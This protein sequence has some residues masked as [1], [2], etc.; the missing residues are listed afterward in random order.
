MGAGLGN[1]VKNPNNNYGPQFGFAWDPSKTGKTVIRGGAGL[2]YENYI[3]NNTLFDRPNKLSQGLFFGSG[4]IEL[5]QPR[6]ARLRFIQPAQSDGY[7]HV[8]EW[9]GFSYRGLPA[10]LVGSSVRWLSDL[11]QEYQAAAKAL[12]P[13]S[14]A[15]F[16]GNDLTLNTRVVGPAF[17]PNF[18][19]ARSYQMNIG[20]QRQLAQGRVDCGLHSQR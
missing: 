6:W 1:R 11:Q 3:F 2:Y 10:A 9:C 15:N 16:V 5:H 18:R 14:N 7:R 12:G 20:V 4:S 17:D 19:T 13:Q 8:G